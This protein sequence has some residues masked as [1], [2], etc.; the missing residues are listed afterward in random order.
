MFYCKK[1]VM[2]NTRPGIT[3]DENGVCSACL[4][5]ERKKYIDW[6]KRYAEL[7]TLCNKYKKLQWSR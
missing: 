3:F 7:K 4:N 5:N 2:P 1:C 6:D